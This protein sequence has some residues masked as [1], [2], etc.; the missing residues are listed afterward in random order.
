MSSA[1]DQRPAHHRSRTFS[2]KSHKSGKSHKSHGSHAAEHD[3]KHHRTTSKDKDHEV[4]QHLGGTTKA[5]PNAAMNEV[6]P[7]A[8]ALEK[9]TLQSLRSFRHTD[10]NGNPI[11]EPDLS[12][13]TRSRWERP[14]DTIRSFEAAIDGEYKRR[15]MAFRGG[16]LSSQFTNSRA[17]SMTDASE[18]PS[19]FT[20]RRNS[21]YSGG[22]DQQSRHQQGYSQGYY[23]NRQGPPVR[24]SW[25]ENY[26]PGP[27]PRARYS[28]APQEQGWNRQSNAHSVYPMPGYQQSRDTVNSGGSNGSHS[29]PYTSDPSDNSSIERGGPVKR[30]DLGEQYGFSG[31]GQGPQA[32]LDDFGNTNNHALNGSGYPPAQ[33]PQTYA[34]QSPNKMAGPSG[35]NNP[36]TIKLTNSQGQ[37]G[38]PPVPPHGKPSLLSRKS[39]VSTASDK[40]DKRQSWFKK[41]FSKH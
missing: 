12:N 22:Y 5:D 7:V 30:P 6:Q 8:A 3:H 27:G 2:F 29:E 41:R 25:Q 34:R 1:V 11:A 28:R 38:A 35:S 4:K 24:D 17:N 26:G 33:Y 9:P 18:A 36:N 16:M 20:S 21:Y 39:A 37:S 31:F 13:P 19:G 40:T 15:S 32:T 23:G 14:L 10:S